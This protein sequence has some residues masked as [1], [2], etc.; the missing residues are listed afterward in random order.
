LSASIHYLSAQYELT[1]LENNHLQSSLEMKKKHKKKGQVLPQLARNSGALTMSP[2][3]IEEA[4]GLLAQKKEEEAA[5]ITRIAQSKA[6]KQANKVYKEQQAIAACE[7]R[8]AE[9]EKKVERGERL[10]QERQKKADARA[11]RRTQNLK[12]KALKPLTKGR[13]KKQVVGNLG[14]GASGVRGGEVGGEPEPAPL[15]TVTKKGRS[16]KLPQKFR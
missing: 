13:Q 14:G 6:A 15:L 1:N 8:Q 12:R 3:T 16:I 5:E 7:K 10:A 11:S 4:L 9:S 2:A